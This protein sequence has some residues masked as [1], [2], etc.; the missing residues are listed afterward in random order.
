MAQKDNCYNIERRQVLYFMTKPVS[1]A[2]E[3]Q[4][5]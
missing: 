5:E 2:S 1:M 4:M 3:A